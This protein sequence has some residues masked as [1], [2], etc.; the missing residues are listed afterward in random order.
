MDTYLQYMQI[1]WEYKYICICF[2]CVCF[3]WLVEKKYAVRDVVEGMAY[4]FRVCA[5]N[6]SGAGEFSNA[7]EFVFARD[8]KS[9][10]YKYFV[11]KYVWWEII[12]EVTDHN[13]PVL[14]KTFFCIRI[15]PPGKVIGLKV[16][17]TSYT[18]MVVTWTKP[19]D[20]PG[21]QDEAKGY[22]VEIRQADRIEWSRCNSTPIIM[23]SFNVKGLRSMEMYWV[24]VIAVNDGGESIPEELPNYI[25]A[26]PLPG[27]SSNN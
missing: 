25:L 20:K 16:T 12:V 18:N 13:K 15:E 17:E 22:F 10:Y 8:P 9:T 11:K 1:A 7:S 14:I 19:E 27:M 24:R 23:T 2:F 26:M 4:E 21:I 3:K 6:L 5:I